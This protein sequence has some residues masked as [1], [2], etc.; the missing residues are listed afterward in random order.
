MVLRGDARLLDARDLIDFLEN[1]LEQ[2]NDCDSFRRRVLVAE[3][4]SAVVA[5]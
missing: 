2:L 5:D 4:P 3:S 1:F